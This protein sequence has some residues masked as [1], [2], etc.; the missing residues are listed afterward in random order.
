MKPSRAHPAAYSEEV[1]AD[2]AALLDEH[3]FGMGIVKL[4]DPMAGEGR[5]HDLADHTDTALAITATDIWHW[6]EGEGV[7]VADAADLPYA[8]GTFD[9]IATSPPYGNR[10]ADRLSTDGDHRVTYADRR[11]KDAA[12]GDTSGMQWGR[13]YRSAMTRIWQEARRVLLPGG[14][15]IVNCKDH[16]RDGRTMPVTQWHLTTLQWIG[17]S[18]VGF[19]SHAAPGVQGLANDEA[20]TGVENVFAFR[21]PR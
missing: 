7:T 6:P 14:L 8:T 5:I 21:A 11:G 15:L 18:V 19:R 17:L 2:I 13:E 12:A 4:L 1:L 16:I 10:M 9:A 3:T 20:R